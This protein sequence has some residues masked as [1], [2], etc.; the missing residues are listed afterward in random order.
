MSNLLD[1]YHGHVRSG[2]LA[3]DAAQE[4]ALIVLEALYDQLVGQQP[5]AR[6]SIIDRLMGR[7]PIS[8]KNG[9][10]LYGPVGRGKTR[11]MDLFFAALPGTIPKRRVHFH[12]F[13]IGV[14]DFMHRERQS[15]G[16]AGVDDVLS[17]YANNLAA[18]TKVLCFDEFHVMDVADAMILGRLFTALFNAGIMVVMTSNWAPDDLYKNGLQREL[19]LP[20]I[21]FLKTRMELV[22]V[23][24][25][26][27]YRLERL[28]GRPVYFYPLNTAAD[29]ELDRL[30]V[31]LTDDAVGAVAE[32][33]V[34]GRI[35]VV[36]HA[37]KGVARFGFADLCEKPLAAEDYLAL[38]ASYH[39]LIVD[40]VPKLSYDRRNEAKRFVLLIDVFYERHRRVILSADAP[41]ERLYAVGDHAF[42]FQR[43]VSRLQE[44]QSQQYLEACLTSD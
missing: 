9:V 12:A 16:V 20:F 37:A 6:T 35:I 1:R 2:D 24:G 21:A 34:K 19:F 36:P 5:P 31:D 11:V 39:T 8:P 41:P 7:K 10:Y 13:M 22:R 42:E 44:M 40:H 18:A 3:A 32:I 28:N 33:T 27:D 23:D 4:R 43:T 26:R 38:A 30:F 15:G 25:P 17:R 14:H 29:A